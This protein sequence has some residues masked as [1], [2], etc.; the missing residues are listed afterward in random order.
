MEYGKHPLTSLEIPKIYIFDLP[1]FGMENA[2]NDYLSLKT[3]GVSVGI[4]NL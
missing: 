1:R 3:R 2:I 4:F